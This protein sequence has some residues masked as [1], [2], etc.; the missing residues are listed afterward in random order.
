MGTG[1][2][3]QVA[4]PV[5]SQDV[6]AMV[7]GDFHGAELT[8]YVV[9][10]PSEVRRTRLDVSHDFLEQSSLLRIIHFQPEHH[11]FVGDRI[12]AEITVRFFLLGGRGLNAAGRNFV[13][14]PHV[15]GGR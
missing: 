12:I 2:N 3:G 7:G 13:L 5:G 6:D 11:G 15:D 8:C 4:K 9:A 14:V 10:E 1:E